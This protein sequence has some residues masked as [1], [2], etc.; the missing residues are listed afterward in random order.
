MRIG[1][2][3][4]CFYPQPLEETLPVLV[5]L[6]VRAVEVFVNTE[7]EF[8]PVFCTQLSAQAHSL[9]LDIVSVHPYTS[10]IEGMLFFSDYQRRTE[11]GLAQYARYFERTAALGAHFLTFHGERDMGTQD[12]PARWARKCEVYHR[13]CALASSFGVTLAQENVAWC[14]SG[15]ADYIRALR[16]DVPA[17]GYT[18]DI[19]QTY[20]AGEDWR[21]L[22]EAMGERL[23]NVHINDFSAEQ[24]C[25]L[26][27]A[28]EMDYADLYARLRG[29]GYDGHTLIEVYRTNFDDPA[30]LGR[31]AHALQ[32]F[33]TA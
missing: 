13:L 3:T 7:S 26:P 22:L 8:S 18:L 25:M 20:R 28:G 12:T 14:R 24:S 32:R 27:G 31:A 33:V 6:G 9:G 2:S 19:K 11:D 17:L 5:G 16:R 10:P 21:V 4:A 1:M 23:V 15:R 30:E 29:I